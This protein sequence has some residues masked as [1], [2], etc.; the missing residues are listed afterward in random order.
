MKFLSCN[1][2]FFGADDGANSWP[3]R[4]EACIQIIQAQKPDIICFQEMW[5]EQFLELQAAFPNFASY[6]L[7]HEPLGQHPLNAIF[8]R[9]ENFVQVAAGGYWLSKTP[10]VAGSKSWDSRGIRFANWLRLRD[11][12]TD[13][14]FRLINTHLDHVGWEARRKQAALIVEDT[15]AYPLGYP[16]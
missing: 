2:R 12:S 9:Q 4:K 11:V 7:P 14:E 15:A 16:Q 5:Q 8:Y 13:V 10:H 6:G 1:I 3:Y